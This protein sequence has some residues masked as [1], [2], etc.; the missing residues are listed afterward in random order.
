VRIKENDSSHVLQ[1][2]LN[3][4]TL[5]IISLYTPLHLQRL[6]VT[7]VTDYFR[8]IE[9]D[10]E[11]NEGSWVWNSSRMKQ[12]S[13]K[14]HLSLIS[15]VLLCLYLLYPFSSLTDSVSVDVSLI[16]D[17]S[18]RFPYFH[19]PWQKYCIPSNIF[20]AIRPCRPFIYFV[21]HPPTT[22]I[23]RQINEQI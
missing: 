18:R 17:R 6:K 7:V 21:L 9:A 16:F 10:S 4:L 11:R 14:K 1:L 23:P 2:Q 3:S 20:L 13:T 5:F 22:L 15:R 12:T 8:G 19:Q